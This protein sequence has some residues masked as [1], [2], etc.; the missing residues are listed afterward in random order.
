MYAVFLG[1]AVE[2]VAP[3]IGSVTLNMLSATGTKNSSTFLRGDN[4]FA[5]AG[6][7][8]ESQLLHVRDEK[9]SGTGGGTASA[10]TDNV[11]VLNTILTNEITSASLSSNIITLPTGTYYIN[12]TIPT[13]QNLSNRAHL[14]NTADSS[15]EILGTSQNGAQFGNDSTSIFITG[16]FTIS[17]QKT[18]QIRHYTTRTGSLGEV[19]GDGRTEVY[20]DVQIWKV[21]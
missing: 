16:R 14:Y 1:R 11:R 19:A 9:S 5:S 3:A 17:A 21:A 6:G 13:H 12:A 15:I 7:I 20:T 18:F 10:T 8:F 2:T 4:T